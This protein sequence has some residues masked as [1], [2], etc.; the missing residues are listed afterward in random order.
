M[1]R[2]LLSFLFLFGLYSIGKAQLTINHS[3]MPKAGDTARYS[4]AILDS[5]ILLNYQSNGANQIWR[6]DSLKAQRQNVRSFYNS[7]NT[8]YSINNKIAEKIAD[9]VNQQ[10]VTLTDVYEFYT[11]DSNTYSKDQRAVT[12]QTGFFPL[13]VTPVY[14]DKDEVYQFPLNYNDSDS[15][16]FSFSFN[17]QFPAAYYGSTGY[18]INK[19][20]G[21][22]TIHTPYGSFNCIRVVTDIVSYDSIS[23]NNNNSGTNSHLREYKWLTPQLAIPALTI[24]GVV[25]SGIFIPSTVE[26]RDSIRNVPTIFAPLAIFSVNPRSFSVGDTV[27][28]NNNSISI[29]TPSYSWSIS[30]NTF[31]YINGSNAQSESPEVVFTDSGYYDVQLIASNNHGND[32]MRRE[33]YIRV[34]SITTALSKQLQTKNDI[35][36]FPN[37]IKTGH[38]INLKGVKSYDNIK[39]LTIEGKVIFQ[40]KFTEIQNETQLM[41][42]NLKAGHY[43]IQLVGKNNIQ[44]I[45]LIVIN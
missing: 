3:H 36:V 13:K 37:P 5:S 6:F 10:G 41:L 32:S 29:N 14:S 21:W 30:P 39:V 33:N 27:K 26:Y 45:Q 42:A 4:I 22:G 12:L 35:K 16:T 19:V 8:P 7:A 34:N 31:N 17:N 20:D 1:K 43:F 11:L 24:S 23:F 25:T 44:T 38:P 18:R 40:K 2:I 9:T 28:F 15:S